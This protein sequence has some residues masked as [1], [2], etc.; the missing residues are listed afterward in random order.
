MIN[1]VRST[2]VVQAAQIASA[3]TKL[4]ELTNDLFVAI[5]VHGHRVY[6]AQARHRLLRPAS[7]RPD[8]PDVRCPVQPRLSLCCGRSWLTFDS[9]P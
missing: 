3:I 5:C 2:Q 8:A 1:D 6:H 4:V 9:S 7:A